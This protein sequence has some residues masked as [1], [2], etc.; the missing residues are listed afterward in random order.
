MRW[1][2]RKRG[3]KANTFG[4][5]WSRWFCF[6]FDISKMSPKR[7]E[8]GRGGGSVGRIWLF[9]GTKS[10]EADEIRGRSAVRRDGSVWAVFD[11][12]GKGAISKKFLVLTR[13]NYCRFI[14]DVYSI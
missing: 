3:K 12:D 9:S 8:L 1:K 6:G 5:S 4:C 2:E 11:T 13:N 7:T 14:S 10:P